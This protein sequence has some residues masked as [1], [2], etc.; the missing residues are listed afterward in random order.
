MPDREQMQ[1]SK[2]G[3]TARIN[4]VAVAIA[5]VLALGAMT[6][7]A[8]APRQISDPPDAVRVVESLP[9]QLQAPTPIDHFVQSERVRRGDTLASVLA[10][11]GALDDAFLRFV[12]TQQGAGRLALQLKPGRTVRAEIDGAGRVI[13]F[14]YRPGGLEDMVA[15]GTALTRLVIERDG[16]HF[17]A[18]EEI[19][20]VERERAT[21]ALE[22]RTT[23][24]AAAD[25]VDLPDA[26]TAQ[27]DR[28]FGN[29]FELHKS[30]RR[31]DR[32]RVVYETIKEAGSYDS[33]VPGRV[34]AVELTAQGVPHEAVWFERE[35]RTAAGARA[36][37]VQAGS[38]GAYY[39]FN[40]E[41]LKKSF[42]RNPLVESRVMSGFSDSRLHPVM[43]DWR[44]HKGVDFAAPIG[45]GV[46]AVGDGAIEFLGQQRGYGN[47]VIVKH[48]AK[49]TTV[50]AHLN[51]FPDGLE[52]GDRVARGETIGFVGQTGWAT[53]PHLHF[54]FKI[55]GDHADPL[56]VALPQSSPLDARERGRFGALAQAYRAELA[57]LDE[58]RIARF[59]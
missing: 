28:I 30:V 39:S 8:V 21:R 19:V 17:S 9:L 35:A 15:R 48:A 41:G 7:V 47:V 12:T 46:R 33:P 55:A 26:V 23:L 36:R 24:F 56:T 5:S 16:G 57:R 6:A 53:G 34:L 45:T 2:S 20:E 29:E 44:A 13:H 14:A 51:G 38:H 50:Y 18:R 3:F 58:I 52:T 49:I 40:G 42:L 25:A 54:E 31:G 37:R 59:E 32:M 43:R 22:V 4:P 27:I 11:M 1:G 10:R